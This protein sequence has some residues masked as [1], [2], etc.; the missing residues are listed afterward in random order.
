MSYNGIGLKTARGSGTSGY[1]QKSLAPFGDRISKH[2][3]H[4]KKRKRIESDEQAD[5]N[6]RVDN[7]KKEA[8]HEINDHNKRRNIELKCLELRDKLEDDDVND[9]IIEEKIRELR[10]KLLT[11]EVPKDSDSGKIDKQD[12]NQKESQGRESIKDKESENA[13][14]LESKHSDSSD[15][16][17]VYEYLPRYNKRPTR[18]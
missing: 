7:A 5:H 9:D 3:E 2:E 12:E 14:L 6:E 11:A 8:R 4:Q 10:K 15:K 18:G 16:N 1:V 13:H 17:P